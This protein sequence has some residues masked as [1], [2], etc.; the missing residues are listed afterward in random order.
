M[1]RLRPR[2][3]VG[4]GW[5]QEVGLGG[6]GRWTVTLVGCLSVVCYWV[7]INMDVPFFHLNLLRFFLRGTLRA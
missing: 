7:V 3:R 1:F 2:V 5:N 6:S 4:V